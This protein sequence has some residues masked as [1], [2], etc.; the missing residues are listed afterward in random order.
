[1]SFSGKLKNL[2]IEH[3]DTQSSLAAK[4][5]VS[6]NA[7]YNWENGKREPN[8]ETIIKIADIYGVS[9]DYLMGLSD[10]EESL[11]NMTTFIDEIDDYMQEVGEFLYYNPTHKQLF[12]ASMEV[13]QKDVSLATEMLN[14]INGKSIE[15]EHNEDPTHKKDQAPPET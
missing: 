12:D 2:R 8:L 9:T 15:L 6:Q 14:R 4:L 7:V 10:K 11:C 3:G 1:M 13:K 5:N